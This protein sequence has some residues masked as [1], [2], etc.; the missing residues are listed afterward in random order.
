MAGAY[1][2][3]MAQA[4]LAPRG[5]GTGVATTP[6]ATS[7][8]PATGAVDGFGNPVAGASPTTTNSMASLWNHGA[9]NSGYGIGGGPAGPGGYQTN[10]YFQN[11]MNYNPHY[12]WNNNPYLTNGGQGGGIGAAN[13]QAGGI[14]VAAGASASGDS[15]GPY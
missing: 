15:G 11:Y 2:N 7:V 14:G 10:P 13:G 8:M 3:A 5:S 4:L 1:Q 9:G 12:G 6:T